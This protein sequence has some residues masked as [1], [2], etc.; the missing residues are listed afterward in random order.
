MAWNFPGT[1][2]AKT[3]C[4]HCRGHG[5]D[6]SWGTKIPHSMAPKKQGAEN[7][8]FFFS[9]FIFISWRLITLQ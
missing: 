7:S 2:V 8:P 9:P 1:P 4:F 3:P 6:P 5:F